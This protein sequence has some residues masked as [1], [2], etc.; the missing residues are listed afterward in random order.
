MGL[1]NA[2]HLIVGIQKKDP[3]L[4]D[5]LN[6]FSNEL[7]RVKKTVGQLVF[8]NSQTVGGRTV[9]SFADVEK[10][11]NTQQKRVST[12][13]SSAAVGGTGGSNVLKRISVRL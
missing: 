7:E 2:Q 13:N 6:L 10:E 8:G 9:A 4:F 11:L 1:P 5:L 12:A 3:R